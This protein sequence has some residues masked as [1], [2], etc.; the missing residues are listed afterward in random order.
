MHLFAARF[1]LSQVELNAEGIEQLLREK[2]FSK[3]ALEQWHRFFY[4]IQECAFVSN[5][6]MTQ[7]QELAKRAHVWLKQLEE[8]I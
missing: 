7:E 3:D 5:H 2:G 6:T 1:G 4:A 8:K